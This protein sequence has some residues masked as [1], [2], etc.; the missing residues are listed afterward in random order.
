M[1]NNGFSVKKHFVTCLFDNNPVFIQ[2]LAMSPA[3][4]ITTTLINGFAMGVCTTAVIIFSNT[5]ISIFKKFIPKQLAIPSYIVIISGFVTCVEYLIKAYIPNLDK[6]LGIFIPL[7][8]VNCIILARAE[9]FA[10]KNPPQLAMLD[11]LFTGIG[12]TFSLSILGFTR[13]LLGT[14]SVFGYH[15]PVFKPIMFFILSAGAFLTL[16]FM[17]AI[18][19]LIIDKNKNGGNK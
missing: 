5:L 11:G 3:L 9:N 13:E 17:I 6:S 18:Y 16:G 15:I 12:F 19:N 7:M 8:V 10:S 1:S 2:L 14:G 4:A